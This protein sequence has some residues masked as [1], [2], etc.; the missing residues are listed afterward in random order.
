MKLKGP[1]PS[2]VNGTII[3]QPLISLNR[4]IESALRAEVIPKRQNMPAM[5]RVLERLMKPFRDLKRRER[6]LKHFEMDRLSNFRSTHDRLLEIF[7]M[8]FTSE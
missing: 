2:M 1:F 4:I 6:K 8:A 3:R 7:F 5:D